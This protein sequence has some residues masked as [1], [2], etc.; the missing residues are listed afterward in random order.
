MGRIGVLLSFSRV[1]RNSAKISDVKI[2]PG[3]GPNITAEHFAPAGDDSYP[4]TTDYV[5]TNE[6]PRTGGETV[7]GYVDPINTPKANE[8]DK[9]IYA[10]DPN[11]GTP[12]N[13]VWLK[14]D[15]SV[16]ISNDNGS[17]LLRVDGGSI[18]T[19]PNSTFDAAANGSIKGDNGSGSFELQSGGDFLVNG[20][21]IDTSGNITSPAIITG[22]QVVAPSI[23]G[24]GKELSDHNHSQANDSGGNTEQDTGPNN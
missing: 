15:G 5:V 14:N 2:D 24:N 22:A 18:I 11:N 6:I 10:R 9:R 17:V 21:T 8:G 7:V 1:E 4:L 20:V 19:T 13:E 3:G 12:V 23:L 16:L